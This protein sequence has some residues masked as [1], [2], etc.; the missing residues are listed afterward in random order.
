[1]RDPQDLIRKAFDYGRLAASATRGPWKLGR[2]ERRAV[3]DNSREGRCDL[4]GEHQLLGEVVEDGKTYHVHLIEDGRFESW[5]YIYSET[6]LKE[7][8]GNFDQSA[9]GV[10]QCLA[11]AELIAAAPDIA[12]L[13]EDLAEMLREFVRE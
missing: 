2:I 7:V 6:T 4:C 11:D 9:G 13:A 12:R 8:V 10:I 1:M 5:R 3:D